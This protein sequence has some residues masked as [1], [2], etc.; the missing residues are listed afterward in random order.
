MSIVSGGADLYAIIETGGLQFKVEN[1]L[2]LTVPRLHAE[3]GGKIL[4]DRV[5]LLGGEGEPK[6]GTPVVASATVAAT[7]VRHLRGPKIDVYH[8]KRRK[9]HEK[10]TG[11]RQEMTEIQITAISGS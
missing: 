4:F 2:R 6:V 3:E 1:G 10:K 11:H 8:R 9:G 5:L 7:V